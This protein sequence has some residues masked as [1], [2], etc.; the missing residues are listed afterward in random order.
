M[1]AAEP[2]SSPASSARL[3]SELSPKCASYKQRGRWS[4][5][6]LPALAQAVPTAAFN[7]PCSGGPHLG[8]P[9]VAYEDVQLG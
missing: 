5:C 7:C 8:I 1:T 9:T 2:G 4:G 3:R 6:W